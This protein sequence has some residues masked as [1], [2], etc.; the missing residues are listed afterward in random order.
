[1]GTDCTVTVYASGNR[2]AG[3]LLDAAVLRVELLEA[4]WSRFRPTSELNRLNSQAGSGPVEVSADLLRLVWTMKE[5]WAQTQGLLDPTILTSI[6]AIGYDTDFAS[7]IARSAIEATNEHLRV[8]ASP[9]MYDVVMAGANV[10]LPLGVGLDPGAIG[11][12]LAGDIIVEELR[13]AGA[14]GVIVNLGGDVVFAGSPG[15]DPYWLVAIEDERVPVGAPG[16][17]MSNLEFDRVTDRGAVATSTTL[18]RRWGNGRHHLIDPRTGNVAVVDIVQA[19]VAA[20]FGWR[21]EMAATAALLL[22]ADAGHEWLEDHDFVSV[23]LPAIRDLG[24]EDE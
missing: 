23:L 16:R 1:M 3:A 13:S 14:T 11:K 10:T 6:K 22:G 24:A 20:D 5:A 12:G 17:I 4:C 21:A 18:K 9:G 2:A 19:T 8:E 7:V 15:D